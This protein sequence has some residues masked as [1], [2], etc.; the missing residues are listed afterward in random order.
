MT[1]KRPD[2]DRD[3]FDKEEGE[4]ASDDESLSRNTTPL[5]PVKRQ[6]SPDRSN[7]GRSKTVKVDDRPSSYNGHS[8]DRYHKGSSQRRYESSYERDRDQYTSRQRTSNRET[9]QKVTNGSNKAYSKLSTSESNQVKTN[10][11][12]MDID[13]KANGKRYVSITLLKTHCVS[14]CS[15][16]RHLLFASSNAAKDDDDDIELRDEDEIKAEEERL[17][18]ER[19][20]RR[21]AILQKYQSKTLQNVTQVPDRAASISDNDTNIGKK[22]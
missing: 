5:T 6:R 18:E 20:K 19:R 4:I 10:A 7:D 15:D 14:T 16:F 11:T 22:A 9:D 2:N 17:I 12:P 13:Q 3:I 1:S 8:S 21:Q